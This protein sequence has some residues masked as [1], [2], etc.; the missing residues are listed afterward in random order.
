MGQGIVAG[1]A[2][3]RSVRARMLLGG[4]S[5]VAMLAAGLAASPA[6]AQ[7]VTPG[8]AQC[9]V[10]DGVV[11]CSGDIRSGFNS[12]FNDSLRRFVFR[13]LTQP[14]QPPN[15][16][17]GITINSS[18]PDV[19][20]DSS[21]R[22]DINKTLRESGY[23]SA[24]YLG[25]GANTVLNNGSLTARGFGDT[26]GIYVNGRSRVGQPLA[27]VNNGTI[28]LRTTAGDS[29]TTN[30]LNYGILA[31][32]AE[33][34][35]IRNA[36][37]IDVAGVRGSA[38]IRVTDNDLGT[39]IPS[40][41]I[42]NTGTIRRA[43][44]DFAWNAS[45]RDENPDAIAIVL[46][47]FNDVT[48]RNS[49]RIEGG[50]ILVQRIDRSGT[51]TTANGRISIDNSG[52]LVNSRIWVED[53]NELNR[54]RVQNYDIQIT[55]TGT[56]ENGGI[57][58]LHTFRAEG[59]DLNV[60]I[61][62]DGNITNRPSTGLFGPA[63]STQQAIFVNTEASSISDPRE[64]VE[65]INRGNITIFPTAQGTS[66]ISSAVDLRVLGNLSLLNEG[67]INSGSNPAV[68]AAAFGQNSLVKVL[69]R[70]SIDTN[71]GDSAFYGL[72]ASSRAGTVDLSNSGTISIASTRANPRMFDGDVDGTRYTF[73]YGPSGRAGLSALSQVDIALQSDGDITVAGADSAG[74][75]FKSISYS[76]ANYQDFLSRGNLSAGYS[77]DADLGSIV[78]VNV[79]RN[80][81][82]S[83]NASFGIFGV[84]GLSQDRPNFARGE[85]AVDNDGTSSVIAV[86][87]G[88]TITGGSGMGSGIYIMGAGKMTLNNQGSIASAG[89][90]GTGGVLIGDTLFSGDA[91]TPGEFF[92][93]PNLRLHL[94]DSVNTGS[95]ISTG[96]YGVRVAN[97]GLLNF[98]NDGLIRG[99]EGSIGASHTSQIVNG[100]SGIL[101]GRIA[102]NG[103]GSVLTNHGAIQVSS[104]GFVSHTINGD[105]TQSASGLLSL[106][107]GAGGRDT[108]NVTGDMVFD[109][110]LR[111]AL[112]APS[113]SALINVGG[114]LTLG[115][116]LSVTDA[117]GFG[118]GVY[119][120]FN[121]GGTLTDNGM[122]LG[123]L[124]AGANGNIQTVFAGQ[125]N[126]VVGRG[127]QFWDGGNTTANLAVDGGSG[128]WNNT[129]TNW[130]RSEGDVN[131]AWQGRGAVFQGTAGTVTIAPEGVSASGLQFAVNG[132]TLTG[133]V[134]TLATP[135]SVR[136]GDGSAAGASMSAT[137]ASVIAGTSGLDKTDFGTLILSG[138]NTYTGG[139]TVSSG[140]L[141]VSRDAN[142]GA[143]SGGV[144]L[145]GGTLRFSAEG[146]SAR[147]F[148]A[149]A[150]GGTL[151][152]A[153]ALLL[154]GVIDGAGAFRKIG[155]GNLIL[156]GDSSGFGGTF[157]LAAGAMRLDGQLGGTL[158]VA[159]GTRLSG[160]G[161]LRNAVISGTVNPGTGN[162]IGT[163]NASGNVTFAAGSTYEVDVTVDG[164]ADRLNVTGTATLQGGNVSA[165][166]Q[167]TNNDACGASIT[168]TILTAQGGISGTFAGVSTNYAFLT[169][170]LSY[171]ANNVRLTLARNAA[172]FT[173]RGVT[174]NQQS[175]AAAAER[176]GCGNAVYNAIIP[177]EVDTARYAFDQLSGEA[178]ASA[179]S[180]LLDD[181][182]FFR[183]AMLAPGER[184][185]A[186]G[187]VYGSWGR[188]DGDGN[189]AQVKRDG[190]GL[191]AGVDVP[192]GETFSAG[193]GGGYSRSDYA[194]ADRV[195]SAEVESWHLGARVGVQAGGFDLSAGAAMAWH[196]F[197]MERAIVFPG[198]SETA[199]SRYDGETRQAFGR[200]GYAMRL[201]DATAVEPFAE[202]AWV[203]VKTD[204]FAETGGAAALSGRA[205]TDDAVF[206]TLGARGST[207]VGGLSLSGRLGWRHAFDLDPA[208]SRVS[209]A[210]GDAFTVTGAPIAE[211][212]LVV[213]AGAEFTF[214]RGARLSVGY[215]GQMGDG[216]RDHGARAM[217]RVPF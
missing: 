208:R 6:T 96:G 150:L 43:D 55:N 70:G 14:I 67:S 85:F 40:V 165:L 71:G 89:S 12:G 33:S 25:G 22:V 203:E 64:N 171:D 170:T 112:G 51:A 105:Y 79:T 1:I 129:T 20:L 174:A 62:N 160:A 126:L 123:P 214:G 177:L 187:N 124:P 9:P 204:A 215:S 65:V 190:T 213:D 100:G 7:Q 173:E 83:G 149:G 99:G 82:A 30:Y 106:R 98:R 164:R 169:P 104:P 184:R 185:G 196:S 107:S 36:G 210:G 130:T 136:V 141:Q 158:N 16:A 4:A 147:N 166:F 92:V 50:E 31:E 77:R 181:S 28:D 162:G 86:A 66:N 205:E 172:T 13:D 75:Y 188:M 94:V 135:A 97:G 118:D 93:A 128:V 133:G 197:D 101:D 102:L 26:V 57:N 17:N 74:I 41:L 183:D 134:L 8:S 45:I 137:I 178:H 116:T 69:N 68:L 46:P 113:S 27:I 192:L 163:L 3:A 142:L 159:S 73:Y 201:S 209:F 108:F 119:R 18:R 95:I 198:F 194:V 216:V 207:Q 121:Y 217:L 91:T 49:G 84:L 138:T 114:N 76:E 157:N 38:G 11:T 47:F 115:G 42:E 78:S 145:N 139:T 200:V 168:S 32:Q 122:T 81:T 39:S 120:I 48:I 23:V 2:R 154:S 24:L 90:A 63:G 52:D 5:A 179:R 117:G 143:A 54:R 195:S 202:V 140:V 193:I 148:T 53:A 153:N 58:F 19:E 132:Y 72:Q 212:A 35:T 191:F 56:I 127:L 125:V 175:S 10:V 189:A 180:G 60:R 199:S 146:S 206:T 29:G 211:D 21:V 80:I 156:T 131:E 152:N 87:P 161:T 103:A 110:Q 37:L 176:L 109:G 59:S 151:E 34:L 182:R 61:L 186:W 15:R 44:L 144:T 155:A 111:L 167:G 88:V